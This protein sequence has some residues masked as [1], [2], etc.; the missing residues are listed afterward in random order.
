MTKTCRCGAVWVSL[1]FMFSKWSYSPHWNDTPQEACLFPYPLL[2]ERTGTALLS[3][4]LLQVYSALSLLWSWQQLLKKQFS[5]SELLSVSLGPKERRGSLSPRARCRSPMCRTRDFL[6]AT[7]LL[8]F[9]EVS[10]SKVQNCPCQP[11]SSGIRIRFFSSFFPSFFLFVCHF[12][13]C[14]WG[15]ILLVY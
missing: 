1:Y 2:T 7:M 15:I 4:V 8:K 13:W 14:W 11:C 12:M 3:R 5:S 10:Q 9:A 6:E